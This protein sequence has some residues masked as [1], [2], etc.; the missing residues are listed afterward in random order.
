MTWFSLQDITSELHAIICWYLDLNW[1]KLNIS[2]N[3][4]LK[5]VLT[6]T[7]LLS[8]GREDRVVDVV[9]SLQAGWTWKCGAISCRNKS[10]MWPAK[11]PD[12]LWGP[13]SLQF[14]EY[15]RLFTRGS[16]GSVMI[17]TP[18]FHLVST[19]RMT[20]SKRLF[21]NTFSWPAQE[22]F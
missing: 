4:A 15:Q 9:T 21:F 13:T 17:L 1:R 19:L 7:A 16:S 5:N 2:E 14:S 11:H 20:W 22:R 18:H 12:A 10:F 6:C 8:A 3:Y